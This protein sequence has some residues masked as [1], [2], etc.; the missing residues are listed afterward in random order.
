MKTFIALLA[1]AALVSCSSADKAKA[2]KHKEIKP[3]IVMEISEGILHPESVLYSGEHGVF[4]VSNVASGNPVE[5][6]PVGYM[7]KISRDGKTVTAK[8][9][10]GLHAPKGMTIVGDFI[11]VADVTRVQKISISKSKI[12]KTINVKGSKFLNDITQD[13]AGNIYVT[14]MF[15]DVLHRIQNDKIS[16][17][18]KD[19]R[20]NALN[21]LFTDGKEHLMSTRWGNEMDPQT[22]VT[23]TPGD[24]AVIPL[25]KPT[26]IT[27][28]TTV[29]G[30][31][32]GIAVDQG[33]NLWI[34]DWMNGNV[35]MM[36]KKGET[37]K[38]FNL[39][40]GT[41]DLSIV[42]D[43]N[44]LV[45]PQMNQNKIIFIQL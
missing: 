14:D 6:K 31:L 36:N 13:A 43:Q 24:M 25:A 37:K 15:T 7:S 45:I 35:F 16:P 10:T 12:V 8:W 30:N 9:V 17:W 22:W 44:L 5:T 28:V 2:P 1:L 34:S 20:I 23:K 27:N 21:G 11:Y 38:M 4:F 29:Q 18:I 26:D 19:P 3:N 33:G 39:G 40:S 41:A 32:D 42:K